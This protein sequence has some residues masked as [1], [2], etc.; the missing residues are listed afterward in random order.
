MTFNES[1]LFWGFL[2]VYGIV[3]YALSPVAPNSGLTRARAPGPW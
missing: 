1:I 2:L 3:M